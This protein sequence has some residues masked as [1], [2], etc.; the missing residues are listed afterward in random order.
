MECSRVITDAE[1]SETGIPLANAPVKKEFSNFRAK[2]WHAA[3]DIVANPQV[4]WHHL[5]KEANMAVFPVTKVVVC[6]VRV[7]FD[8]LRL[9]L[10]VV[11]KLSVS[12]NT[13]GGHDE[14]VKLT[15]DQS[16]T[17]VNNYSNASLFTNIA[18]DDD[19]KH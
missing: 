3:A 7:R 2:H 14:I 15:N 17:E 11:V 16:C 12:L 5:L 6:A 8:L 19:S 1:V 18:A 10:K 9:I 13:P 4:H